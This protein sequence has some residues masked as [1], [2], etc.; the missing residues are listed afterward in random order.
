MSTC[1]NLIKCRLCDQA[2]PGPNVEATNKSYLRQAIVEE[3]EDWLQQQSMNGYV[4]ETLLSFTICDSKN[5]G[6]GRD[7]TDSVSFL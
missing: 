1:G 7:S 3:S 4:L 5:L 2:I 6:Y